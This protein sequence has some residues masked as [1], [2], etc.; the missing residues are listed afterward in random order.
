[1]AIKPAKEGA[2]AEVPPIMYRPPFS[3]IAYPSCLDAVRETSGVNRMLPLGTPEPVCQLGRG[4][5]ALEPPP[6]A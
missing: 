6:P 5:I 1:M 4:H 2:D 3:S